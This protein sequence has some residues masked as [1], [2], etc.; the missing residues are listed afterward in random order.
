MKMQLI[1][2]AFGLRYNTRLN[3]VVDIINQSNADLILFSGYTLG[4]E[5]HVLMLKKRIV[6]KRITSVFELKGDGGGYE[7]NRQYLL[8]NGLVK[9]LRTHQLFAESNEIKNNKKLAEGFIDE[10]IRTRHFEVNGAKVLL[11]LCGE[12][13]ILKNKQNEGNKVVF[14]FNEDKQLTKRFNDIIKQTQIV[15]NPI[16]TPMGNQGKMH[17]RRKWLSENNRYYFSASNTKKTNKNLHLK[18]LQYAYFNGEP[19]VENECTTD[20]QSHYISRTF[21]IN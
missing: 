1:S 2:F 15:L 20:E 4:L 16:H 19:I 5:E 21:T 9:K 18:S 13:N 6:N 8:S 17:E 7:N 11:L 10:L 14:R 3:L 12:N